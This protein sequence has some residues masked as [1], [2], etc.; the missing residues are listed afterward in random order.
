MTFH[1]THAENKIFWRRSSSPA[2]DSLKFSARICQ[3]PL[4]HRVID[5]T[6]LRACE[7]SRKSYSR[8]GFGFTLV[9]VLV[10]VAIFGAIASMALSTDM[11]GFRRYSFGDKRDA[12]ISALQKTRSEA[13]N[14]V[15]F[16]DTCA[17]GVDHSVHFENDKYTL[18]QGDT[19]NPTD[20][21]NEVVTVN[22]AVTI[23]DASDIVFAKNSGDAST[24]STGVWNVVIRDT[25]GHISTTTVT[26]VGQISW[27]N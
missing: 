5:R 10:V 2:E 21:E 20:S 23:S 13:M 16:G 18:F 1:Q 12:L 6:K 15:C 11:S 27:T 8:R 26:S 3:E 9:E 25:F 7:C 4:L 14:G 22:P 24:T 17:G 19:Y